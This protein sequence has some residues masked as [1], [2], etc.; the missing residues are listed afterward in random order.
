M[1]P[2]AIIDPDTGELISAAEIAEVPYIAFTSHKS[3][4]VT[5]RLIRLH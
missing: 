4:P 2:N 5:A 3:G 1:Y